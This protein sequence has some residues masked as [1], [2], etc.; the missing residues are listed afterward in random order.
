MGSLPRLLSHC[1]CLP[2][3]PLRNRP[4]RA[5]R[6]PSLHR[7]PPNLLPQQPPLPPLRANAPRVMLRHRRS[8]GAR[9]RRLQPQLRLRRR[10]LL[11]P[12]LRHN[13]PALPRPQLLRQRQNPPSPPMGRRRL[14]PQAR[15]LHRPRRPRQRVHRRHHLCRLQP[16]IRPRRMAAARQRSPRQQRPLRPR[17]RR[18]PLPRRRS[19]IRSPSNCAA[20]PAESTTTSWAASRSAPR[21]GRFIRAARSRRSGSRTVTPMRARRPRPT[22]WPMSPPTGLIPPIIQSPI[23]AR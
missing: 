15:R 7:T 9:P 17:P 8:R 22:I 13:R 10:P 23:S 21:S 16:P 3:A 1:C 5:A 19:T 6:Q 18:R 4:R 11:R 20:S 12:K 14:R 2:A